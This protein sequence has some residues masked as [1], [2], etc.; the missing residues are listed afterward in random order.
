MELRREVGER[1]G[2]VLNLLGLSME[3][4]AQAL[5]VS[6]SAVYA[7]IKGRNEPPL[8][9]FAYLHQKGV[10]LNFL[11]SGKGE[12]LLGVKIYNAGERIR[13]VRESLKLSKEMFCIPL[14]NISPFSI[15]MYEEGEPC[16]EAVLK[17]ISSVYGVC[18]DY[19]AYGTGKVF[20]TQAFDLTRK[21]NLQDFKDL[22]P[23]KLFVSE[24]PSEEGELFFGLYC[25]NPKEG[26]FSGV[27]FYDSTDYSAWRWIDDFHKLCVLRENLL[28]LIKEGLKE[29]EIHDKKTLNDIAEGKIHALSV[30]GKRV[31]FPFLWDLTDKVFKHIESLKGKADYGLAK[32]LVEFLYEC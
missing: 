32:L 31:S 21:L 24:C 17:E 25:Y 2:L 18:F 22:I 27:F 16:P 7:W 9:L 26:I 15:T 5:Q 1:I 3:D 4:V 12:P 10:N 6:V 13:H 23:R 14:H 20:C 28:I 8:K 29:V 19:L 30:D 11:I